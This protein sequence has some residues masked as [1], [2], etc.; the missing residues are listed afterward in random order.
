[1]RF[2]FSAGAFSEFAQTIQVFE[3]K[4]SPGS[5][6]IVKRQAPIRLIKPNVSVSR[7]TK[8]AS[9]V[10]G[11]LLQDPDRADQLHR[12]LEKT[13]FHGGEET[14]PH[15]ISLRWHLD[16]VQY[17]VTTETIRE[18]QHRARVKALSTQS[19]EVNFYQFQFDIKKP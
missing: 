11:L 17:G 3:W 8:R 2:L 9:V 4:S 7:K 16:P 13:G 14:I 5:G 18:L 6:P 12:A 15:G 10:F 1:L 19:P